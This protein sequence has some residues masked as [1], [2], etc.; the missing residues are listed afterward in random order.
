MME[1]E[2]D[3]LILR[4]YTMDDLDFFA[5]LWADPEVV[6]YIGEG[7]TRRRDEAADDELLPGA[8]CSYVYDPFGNRLTL[9]LPHENNPSNSSAPAVHSET[10]LKQF[11]WY[12]CFRGER[13]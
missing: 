5:S 2:T 3:R 9:T 8:D 12:L 4:P 10:F 1:L 11:M 7:V 6:H 13:G